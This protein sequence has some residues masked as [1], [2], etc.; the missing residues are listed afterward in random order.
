MDQVARK[1]SRDKRPLKRRIDDASS[2]SSS[3]KSISTESNSV[4]DQSFLPLCDKVSENTIKKIRT[5]KF[6]PIR[7]FVADAKKDD[8]FSF[9]QWSSAMHVFMALDLTFFPRRWSCSLSI[10]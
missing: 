2:V 9:T 7:K 4:N 1:S 3:V 6:V 8:T 10:H 5:R